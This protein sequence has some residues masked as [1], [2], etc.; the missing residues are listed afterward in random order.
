[1]PIEEGWTKPSTL[2]T[3]QTISPIADIIEKTSEWVDNGGALS[4]DPVLIVI[5]FLA[6]KHASDSVI[7]TYTFVLNE[8]FVIERNCLVLIVR[9]DS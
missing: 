3:G 4:F 5:L 1:M 6:R 8:S 2:I 9:R 7:D